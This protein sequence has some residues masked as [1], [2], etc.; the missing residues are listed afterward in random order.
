MSYKTVDYE[1]SFIDFEDGICFLGYAMNY[2]IYEYDMERFIEDIE[3]YVDRLG[4]ACVCSFTYKFN[5]Q[6][7]LVCFHC[8]EWEDEFLLTYFTKIIHHIEDIFVK[9]GYY[10]LE[11]EKL[12]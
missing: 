2:A 10:G 11:L 7:V 8:D 1:E 4:Y 9:D 3:D 12:N 5:T 6:I